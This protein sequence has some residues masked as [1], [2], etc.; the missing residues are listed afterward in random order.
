MLF[1]RSAKLLVNTGGIFEQQRS[2]MLAG[3]CERIVSSA[4]VPPVEDPIA[5]FYL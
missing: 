5:T 3:S 1:N 2:G 4:L